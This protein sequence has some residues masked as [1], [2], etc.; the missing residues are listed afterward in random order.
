MVF[1]ETDMAPSSRNCTTICP[2]AGFTNWGR[3]EEE[4]ER[5]LW[6]QNLGPI[7]C[8]NA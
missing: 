7:P 2:R 1:N 4:E 5:R 3:K 6:V 8:R